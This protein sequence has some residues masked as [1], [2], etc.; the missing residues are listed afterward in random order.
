MQVKLSTGK[1]SIEETYEEFENLIKN[2]KTQGDYFIKV[3]ANPD[4][5][6]NTLGRCIEINLNIN[7]V[8]WYAL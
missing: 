3:N 7:H 6:F 2:A 4:N 1:I 8:V 5:S